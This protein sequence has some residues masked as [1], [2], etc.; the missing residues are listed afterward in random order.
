[1]ID[2]RFINLILIKV[3]NAFSFKKSGNLHPSTLVTPNNPC[4]S[5]FVVPSNIYLSAPIKFS[6]FS[7]SISDFFVDILINFFSNFI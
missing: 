5:T 6:Y 1:M 7:N 3:N 2:I 4:S